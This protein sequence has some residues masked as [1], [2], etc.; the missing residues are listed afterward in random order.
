MILGRRLPPLDALVVFEA[1]VR[2]GSFSRAGRE[3]ALTQ[4]AVSRQIAK[5][6]AFVG[7]S[8]FVRTPSGVHL[9]SSGET[10]AVE[11]VRLLNEMAGVT[12]SVRAW[13]GPRQVTLACSRGI[14]D[15]WL[16]PRL[17]RMSAEIPELE[18]RL[19]VTDDFDHLRLD[20][21]DL[22]IFYRRHRPSGVHA[23]K[24]GE[25]EIVPVTLPGG[26]PLDEWRPPTLLSIE[27]P[28]REWMGWT[29]WCAGAG[30]AMP[31]DTRHWRLGDYRLAVEAAAEGI[32]IA[33]GWTWI[34]GQQI[35][36]GRL[37]PAHSYRFRTDGGFY[38]IRSAHRHTRRIV[39]E[40]EDWLIASNATEN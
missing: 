8:L 9:T 29:D 21:F 6:E 13:S 16:M 40:L 7:T 17:K 33:L 34:I 19:R 23:V 38:V 24:L 2:V 31:D 22:A 4:S 10:Y 32:G 15:L 3:L 39:R 30:L 12:D 36:E 1:V 20:E 25:E 35:A 14:G 28:R 5:L 27:D 18:L 11:I 37:V 26:L